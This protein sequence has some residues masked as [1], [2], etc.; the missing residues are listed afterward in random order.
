[1]YHSRPKL[2]RS[3]RQ[4]ISYFHS[5]I[6]LNNAVK[7][8]NVIC[9]NVHSANYVSEG[10]RVTHFRRKIA[11]DISVDCPCIHVSRHRVDQPYVLTMYLSS[12]RRCEADK[13]FQLFYSFFKLHVISLLQNGNV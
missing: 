2:P 10:S 11:F 12:Q 9:F 7:Y 13:L 4:P 3:P 5:P 8:C 6:I 1:M